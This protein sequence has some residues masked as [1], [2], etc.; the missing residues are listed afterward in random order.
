MW[1]RGAR[2]KLKLLK[3]KYLSALNDI[4]RNKPVLSD[5]G[6]LALYWGTRLSFPRKLSRLTISYQSI[7]WWNSLNAIEHQCEYALELLAHQSP[8]SQWGFFL[9]DYGFEDLLQLFSFIGIS[10]VIQGA[11]FNTSH[12]KEHTML[13]QKRHTSHI[14]ASGLCDFGRAKGNP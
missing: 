9:L 12:A 6:S 7:L 5:V 4:R 3:M 8:P 14:P 13:L 11:S 1:S 2:S 10:L